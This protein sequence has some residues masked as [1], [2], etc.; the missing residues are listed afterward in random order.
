MLFLLFMIEQDIKQASSAA[1]FSTSLCQRAPHSHAKTPRS[2]AGNLRD[3]WHLFLTQ[4]PLTDQTT[5][6]AR[7]LLPHLPAAPQWLVRSLTRSSLDTT[8]HK[9][10]SKSG[11]G[12]W[13]VSIMHCITYASQQN[14]AP[15]MGKQKGKADNLS[16]AIFAEVLGR[17]TDGGCLQD[18]C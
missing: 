15:S 6:Q 7:D 18:T 11:F 17:A 1:L 12:H 8:T 13:E 4:Q 3:H 9:E 10:H 16:L 14:R 5:K 2:A